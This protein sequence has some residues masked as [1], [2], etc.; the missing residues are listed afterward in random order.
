MRQ[1]A[2]I[3]VLLPLVTGDDERFGLVQGTFRQADVQRAFADG[4]AVDSRAWPRHFVPFKSNSSDEEMIPGVAQT[5]AGF[6]IQERDF[7]VAALAE[8]SVPHWAPCGDAERQRFRTK[9]AA[10]ADR[11]MRE[12]LNDYYERPGAPQEWRVT[13]GRLTRP[14]DTERLKRKMDE[15]VTRVQGG[16]EPLPRQVALGFPDFDPPALG[17]D[18]EDDDLSE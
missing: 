1:F 6:I 16:A 15:F 9:L 11:G 14:A 3:G 17:E 8:R 4:I 5:I 18:D 7:T 10:L 12:H 2:A 13:S